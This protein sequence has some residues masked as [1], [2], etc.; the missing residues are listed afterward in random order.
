[1]SGFEVGQQVVLHYGASYAPREMVTTVSRITLGGAV[2]VEKYDAMF[3]ADGRQKGGD[4]F[5]RARIEPATDEALK[6]IAYRKMRQRVSDKA[7]KLGSALSRMEWAR[8]GSLSGEAL[9]EL[10]RAIDAALSVVL[11]APPKEPPQ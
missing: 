8:N 5:Y 7:T 6:R 4:R 2:R 11:P 1:M 9:A 10:E 3:T